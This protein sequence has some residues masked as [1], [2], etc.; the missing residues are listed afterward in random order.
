MSRQVTV[1]LSTAQIAELAAQG[2]VTDAQIAEHM[3]TAVGTL[4]TLLAAKK[5]SEDFAIIQRNWY[6][7]IKTYRKFNIRTTP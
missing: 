1:E 5:P 2:I 3:L 7:R 4:I 6:G